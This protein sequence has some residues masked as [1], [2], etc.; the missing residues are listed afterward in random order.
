MTPERLAELQAADIPRF[1][2]E[3]ISPDEPEMAGYSDADKKAFDEHFQRYTYPVDG[4]CIACGAYLN[5]SFTWG[6]THG[7]GYCSHS[8]C[9]YPYRL[10]H[11]PT[12]AAGEPAR[13]LVI[14]LAEHPN[15]LSW[16]D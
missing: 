12:D 13:R 9:G 4:S 7:H 3:H 8:E 6:F 2:A 10:F 1:S 5:A 14:L 15:D 16:R 11:Y